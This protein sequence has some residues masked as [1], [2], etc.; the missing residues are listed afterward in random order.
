MMRSTQKTSA[1]IAA[2]L[3]EEN[4][5]IFAT[6]SEIAEYLSFGT[7]GK[8]KKGNGDDFWQFR[9][10]S[11]GESANKIDW[12]R[13][14]K[15][16]HVFVKEK[17]AQNP[18][19]FQFWVDSRPAMHWTS[20]PKIAPKSVCAQTLAIGIFLSLRKIGQYPSFL[21]QTSNPNSIDEILGLTNNLGKSAP[22]PNKAGEVL[23]MSDGLEA[24]E[25]WHN[26]FAQIKS[27]GGKPLL[28]IVQDPLEHSFEISGR[29][30]FQSIDGLNQ[31]ILIDDCGSIKRQYLARYEDHFRAL[32]ELANKMEVALFF[33][34]TGTEYLGIAKKIWRS[35]ENAL[36]RGR[37][38]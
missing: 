29:V 38:P 10:L 25:I 8:R 7:Y 26:R 11:L 33:H 4:P 6:I 12:R 16:N 3:E 1:T 34:V 30:Q 22:A 20:D 32:R 35:F 36:A 18:K 15:T 2:S 9:Q 31:K 14:A 13:T 23:L 5:K 17:E 28:V 19:R 37:A 21:G 27:R 24:I